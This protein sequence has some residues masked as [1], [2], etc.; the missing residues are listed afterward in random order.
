LNFPPFPEIGLL[1]EVADLFICLLKVARTPKRTKDGVINEV[2]APG[3][4]SAKGFK[5]LGEKFVVVDVDTRDL[6]P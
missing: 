4:A 3:I 2:L 6:I 5:E 1:Q